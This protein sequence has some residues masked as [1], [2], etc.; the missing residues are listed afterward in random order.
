VKPGVGY[1][2]L[3]GEI[4]GDAHHFRVVQLPINLAMPEAVRLPTQRMPG[5]NVLPVLD[6]ARDLG[7]SVA[8]S[9]TLMQSQLASN[10]PAPVR[11]LFPSL[12]TDAQRA[13]AFV[14]SLP[15]VTTA[16]VGMKQVG[17]LKENL[18]AAK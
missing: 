17:H 1:P 5:G 16:L 11:D 12:E 10:L 9:A 14:R 6:A 18:G 13:I 7:L 8:A 3:G 2:G 4:A 15:G